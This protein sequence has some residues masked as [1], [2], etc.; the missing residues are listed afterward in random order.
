MSRNVEDV[1]ERAG[2]YLMHRT[3]EYRELP[4]APPS[5]RLG[6]APRGSGRRLLVAVGA[7]GA[8]ATAVLVG[9]FI[10]G[11]TP[12]GPAD[13]A[14]AAWSATPVVPTPDQSAQLTTQCDTDVQ[15][16][17]GA[18]LA[19]TGAE[20][21]PLAGDLLQPV[22]AEVRGTT[23]M[24][25]YVSPGTV[26]L[27]ATFADGSVIVRA[28][29]GALEPGQTLARGLDIGGERYMVVTGLLPPGVSGGVVT[30]LR[31]GQ[32]DVTATVAGDRYAAWMPT[33]A[34]YSIVYTGPD[35]TT[36]QVGPF[37]TEEL[38]EDEYA[39]VTT[40]VMPGPISDPEPSPNACEQNPSSTDCD[41]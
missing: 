37:A 2:E 35:G 41:G 10:G 31:P 11:S 24:A 17:Y 21:A 9:T 22:I 38:T 36:Q 14:Q 7:T 20:P 1:L 5:S 27:C 25:V 39:P 29:S 6:P 33:P 19:E 30:V 28:F 23:A 8:L 13:V 34:N 18:G 26:A 40:V 3:A 12:G 15:T 4:V 32:D 16:V